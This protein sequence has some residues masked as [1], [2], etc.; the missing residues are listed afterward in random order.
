MP[1]DPREVDA[2]HVGGD[3]T[4]LDRVAGGLLAGAHAALARLLD[5]AAAAAARPSSWSRRRSS[6]AAG[7]RGSRGG[8]RRRRPSWWRPPAVVVAPPWTACRCHTQ[9]APR[10]RLQR[11][12][13]PN[14][15]CVL[16]SADGVPTRLRTAV[17]THHQPTLVPPARRPHEGVVGATYNA[18]P[19]GARVSRSLRRSASRSPRS[20]AVRR[21]RTAAL[22]RGAGPRRM[23]G[24]EPDRRRGGCAH[25]RRDATARRQA[26][27]CW[28]AA[29]RSA[30]PTRCSR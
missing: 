30:A 1:G 29:S 17:A 14:A 4:D 6:R 27:C 24:L 7:G 23:L 21:W 9:R 13:T 5:V 3:A 26:A 8:R 18:P 2:G 10:A 19:R 28:W 12:P 20:A 22:G 15:S 11:W 25:G 16:P